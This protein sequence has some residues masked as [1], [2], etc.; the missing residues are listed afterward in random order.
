LSKSPI[1]LRRLVEAASRGGANDDKGATMI[2]EPIA[3]QMAAQSTHRHIHKRPPR[4]RKT[5]RS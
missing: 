3:I 1:V 5:R 4:P 2:A